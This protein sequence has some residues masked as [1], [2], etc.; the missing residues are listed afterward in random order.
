MVI[1]L[2]GLIVIDCGDP[3]TPD[4]GATSVTDTTVGSLANHTCDDGYLLVGAT[5]RVC[6]PNETWS[7]DLPTCRLRLTKMKAYVI[8]LVVTHS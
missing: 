8:L 3:G 6:L 1:T 2:T 7:P 4:N 5:Q